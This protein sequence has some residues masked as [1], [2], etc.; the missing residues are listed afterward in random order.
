[1]TDFEMQYCGSLFM[2]RPMTPEAR[3]HLEERVDDEA[4]WLS[5]AL[6]VERRY[7]APLKERLEENGFTVGMS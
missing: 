2:L 5:G 3:T 6:A 4:Q 1:M 7:M